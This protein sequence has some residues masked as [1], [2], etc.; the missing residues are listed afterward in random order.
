MV[1]LF[2][3]ASAAHRGI[4]DW[5]RERRAVAEAP[6]RLAAARA[7]QAANRAAQQRA[8]AIALQPPTPAWGD[9]D[10]Q[11]QLLQNFSIALAERN[12]YAVLR[13][14]SSL[15][16]RSRSR[17]EKWRRQLEQARTAGAQVPADAS[18]TALADFGTER[19]QAGWRALRAGNRA[20]ALTQ[21]TGAVWADADD[22]EAWLG[23][24]L[25][26]FAGRDAVGA[27]TIA[28]LMTPDAATAK[29]RVDRFVPMAAGVDVR[30]QSE[31]RDLLA[32]AATAAEHQR[33]VL[34]AGMVRMAGPFAWGAR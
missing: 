11:D 8:Q 26:S 33:Q 31:I 15:R 12:D 19:R 34:P 6:Q 1:F 9:Y 20:L 24:G 14:L 7:Q 27:L 30:R 28:L 23:Y 18:P 5:L 16:S 13:A 22:G 10:E 29:D 21:F 32:K 3:L 2:T 25:S 4:D 17:Q